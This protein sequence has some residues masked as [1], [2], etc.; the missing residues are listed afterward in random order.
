MADTNSNAYA[1]K[2]EELKIQKLVMSRFKESK[3]HF[4]A[5]RK[6][7]LDQFYKNF[8]SYGGDRLQKLKEIGGDDWMSNMFVPMTA[9]HI[10]TIHPRAVDAKPQLKVD[11]RTKED[12]ARAAY[13]QAHLEYLW[14]KANME[15]KMKDY[16]W[17]ALTYGTTVGKVLWKKDMLIKTDKVIDEIDLEVKDIEIK[18]EYYNDPSFEVVDLYTFFPDPY[19]TCIYDARYS[20]QRYLLTKEQ[21][22]STYANLLHPEFLNSGGGDITDDTTVRL[23]MTG[24]QKGSGANNPTNAAPNVESQLLEV[25][26]YWE[27]NRFVLMVNDVIQKFGPN[28]LMTGFSPFIVNN[29]ERLP[30]EFYGIGI[31]E[32][33]EQPQGTVNVVRNQRID[34]VTL[35][36]QKMF[37]ANPYSLVS[38]KDLVARPFGIIRTTDV[39][40]VVPVDT[41]TMGEAAYKEDQLAL[42]AG[43]MATGI[44]DWSRGQQGP[45]STTATAV[46]TQKEST[47]ER[48][49]LFIKSLETDCYSKIMRYWISMSVQLYETAILDRLTD[50]GV[51]IEKKVEVINRPITIRSIT[52]GDI[53]TFVSKDDLMGMYDYRALS[54]STLAATKELKITRILDVMDRSMTSGVD[55][56]THEMIPN[57]REL[58]EQLFISMDWDPVAMMNEPGSATVPPKDG[59]TG[60]IEEDVSDVDGAPTAASAKEMLNNMIQSMGQ[61]GPLPSSNERV[62]PLP[63]EG[64]QI[65]T[66]INS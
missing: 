65:Q 48:V 10:R 22:M 19:A 20:C 4:R 27:R 9:S 11:G 6:V 8:R 34:N 28:P 5:F 29:Y 31:A 59:G 45:A 44:D 24:A 49:K 32:Q 51:E 47:L 35:T 33:V 57:L 66:A 23:E 12:Q 54:S 16:V 13:V 64:T 40:A 18:E 52:K 63:E 58:W 56:V 1:P 15:S 3:D 36:I 17:Q 50:G 62:S 7:R 30:F 53:K 38:E 26:E 39:N 61:K 37:I 21:V 60:D 55:P 41:P 2:D 42:D 14:E 46:S 43:R 25:C